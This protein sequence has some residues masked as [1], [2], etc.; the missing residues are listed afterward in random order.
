MVGPMTST[1]VAEH[2]HLEKRSSAI[3]WLIAGNPSS[4]LFGAQIIATL[5]GIGGWRIA[6]LGWVLPISLLSILSVIIGLP[7]TSVRSQS[8]LDLENVFVVI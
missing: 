7:S 3:G 6:F 4:F 8:S 2:F 5:I 1:L